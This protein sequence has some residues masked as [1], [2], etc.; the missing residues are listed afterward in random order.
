MIRIGTAG[1]SVPKIAQ[2]RFAGAGT[3][4]ERYARV[5][6]MVEIN[7]TFH[8]RHEKGTFIRWAASVPPDFRFAVKMPRSITH[9]AVLADARGVDELFDDL[10]GL[11][12]KLGVILIQLPPSLA[13]ER[14][15]ARRFL[16]HVR[17]R[18][19]DAGATFVM[20]PRHR[21]WLD[22][23]AWELL[24]E[25][26]CSLVVAD[27]ARAELDALASLGG[28]EASPRATLYVRL[29][30]APRVYWDPYGDAV[31]SIVARVASV[32]AESRWIVF[33]NTAAGA[34]TLDALAAMEHAATRA[35]LKSL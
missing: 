2:A 9:E 27:P 1:W 20:E 12:T 31:R 3:W 34:A 26:G 5:F 15:R 17:A 25:H 35:G 19:E 33:D 16:R 24:A 4:I 29:H 30:G 8:R 6:S 21:S 7:S 32:P 28:A 14:R 11:G 13:L 18:T 23:D 10:A 22:A